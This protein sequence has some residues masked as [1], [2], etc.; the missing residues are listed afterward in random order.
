MV[1]ILQL[2]AGDYFT[3]G[4]MYDTRGILAQSQATWGFRAID[5]DKIVGIMG[6]MGD[7]MQRDNITLL[8][9]LVLYYMSKLINRKRLK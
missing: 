8:E 5:N 3:G 4:M 9:Y 2:G 6:I 1:Y 7:D